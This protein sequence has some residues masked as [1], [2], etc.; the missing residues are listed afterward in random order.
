MS[1]AA[2]QQRRSIDL[3]SIPAEEDVAET[4]ALLGSESNTAVGSGSTSPPRKDSWNG[5]E[6]F[7]GL[8]WWRRPSV[9]WLIGPYVLFTLAYGGILVPRLNLIIGLV[10]RGY[11]ADREHSDGLQMLPI[12]PGADNPQC[13]VPAVQRSVATFSLAISVVSGSLGA[14]TAPRLGALSD[15]YGRKMILVIASC[16]GLF[17]EIIIILAAKYPDVVHYNWLIGAAVI[18]GLAGSFTTGSVASHAYTSD[19]TPPSRRSVSFGYM[20]AC[21]FTGMA[22]GPF[23]AGYFVEWTGSLVSIFYVALGCHVAFIAFISLLLPESLSQRRQLVAREKYALDGQDKAAKAKA[24][25]EEEEDALRKLSQTPGSTVQR[26]L[27]L[28]LAAWLRRTNPFAPLAILW[29]KGT[30]NTRVRRNLLLLAAIDTVLLAAAISIGSVTLL[31]S[32]YQ[33]HWGNFQTSAFMSLLSTVRVA[34]LMV[35]FPVINYLVR[36]RPAARLRRLSG[37]EP[38]EANTGADELDVWLIRSAILSDVLG[39]TGY[40][41]ARSSAVFVLCG[42]VT[43]FGGLGSATVQSALTKHIPADRIGELLGAIGLLQS[44]SRVF[45]PLV[46]N[47]LY[48]AT[49]GSFPQA[50]FVL[51]AAVFATLLLLSFFV[52]PHVFLSD[53]EEAA[54]PQPDRLAEA[55]DILVE[56]T[57]VP[58]I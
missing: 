25:E 53:F 11:F 38:V 18:D 40:I 2:G 36:T 37:E 51:V 24:R 45:A 49:V 28:R 15:R 17:G 58:Q 21:L 30:Y 9:Y 16:G 47:S 26:G 43:A 29:P 20:H 33:F 22:A 48:A 13:Q 57:V 39:L 6:D 55:D 5:D 41:F 3:D 52:R 27:G 7:R 32:E 31:Y 42:V 4:S 12:V 1:V 50:V 35:I 23:L 46:F 34:V 19:C 54:E 56:E 44:L 10:C 8:S 14:F